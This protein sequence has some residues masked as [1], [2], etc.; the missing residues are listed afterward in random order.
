[1]LRPLPLTRSRVGRL[2]P[3]VF[4]LGLA[5]TTSACVGNNAYTTPR[6]LEPGKASVI[7][8]PEITHYRAETDGRDLYPESKAALPR[9]KA[10]QTGFATV[11]PTVA[12]RLGVM[13]KLDAGLYLRSSNV[14]GVDLKFNFLQTRLI[15]LA[16]R[17]GAQLVPACLCFGNESWYYAELPLM[18]S[19]HVS[20]AVEIVLSPGVGRGWGAEGKVPGSIDLPQRLPTGTMGR[21]GLGAWVR[22]SKGLAVFP[23]VTVANRSGND[24]FSWVTAGIG[25]QLLK[26]SP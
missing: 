1:M 17:P 18:A 5:L 20:E 16:L 22:V 24:S 8:A 7:V 15:D 3:G 9:L 21:V 25:F 4:A 14:P 26:G 19:V 10:K 13:N 23:E 12:I 11:L 2:A 6:T